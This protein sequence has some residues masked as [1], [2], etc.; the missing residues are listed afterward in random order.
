MPDAATLPLAAIDAVVRGAHADPFAVLGPHEATQSGANGIAVRVFR[1]YAERIVLRSLLDQR[2]YE[3]RRLHHAGFFEAFLPGA[4][5]DHLD[6]RLRI[7]CTGG[8]TSEIDDPY[9]FG[10]VLTDLDQHLFAEGTHVR[11]F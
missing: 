9:R 3:M 6:Y 11:A 1:P 8:L 7:T 5:R 2:E 10:P 4:R